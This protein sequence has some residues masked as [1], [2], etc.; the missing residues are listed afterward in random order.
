VRLLLGDCIEKMKELPENFVD[1]IICDPPYGLSFMGKKWDYD[2]P[3]LDIWQECLRVLKSGGTALIFAGSRTQHRMACNVEDSGFILKDCIMW[4]YG[5]GFPKATD[6]SKQLDKGHERKVIGKNPMVTGRTRPDGNATKNFGAGTNDDLTEPTT[7]E[8]KLWNGWKSHGLKPAYEPI[9]W[10]T[11]SLTVDKERSILKDVNNNLLFNVWLLLVNTQ[12][13]DTYKS[14]AMVSISLSIVL[15]WNAILGE[16]WK[17][18]SKFTTSTVSKTIIELKTLNFLLSKNTQEDTVGKSQTFQS[19]IQKFQVNGFNL[20]VQFAESCL[21]KEKKNINDILKAIV[22]ENATWNL[23]ENGINV[24][25]V[26]KDLLPIILNAN[27]VLSNVLGGLI[28]ENEEKE[29]REI[30]SF[31]EKSLKL[32]NQD[33]QNTVMSDVWLRDMPEIRPNYSPII[34]AMK[35]NEGSYAQNALEYGVSGL[36]IDGGRIKTAPDDVFGGGGLNSKGDGF[37]GKSKTPYE[38][39]MGFRNDNKQGRFP[40][41]I[42]LDEEA[43]KIIDKDVGDNVSRFFKQVDI[44]IEELSELPIS[45]IS[46]IIGR[47]R[48]TI[49]NKLK[50]LGL[51]KEPKK[52]VKNNDTERVCEICGE[53]KEI[54]EFAKWRSGKDYGYRHICKECQNCR[55]LPKTKEEKEKRKASSLAYAHNVRA[56]DRKEN[57]ITKE[58]VIELKSVGKCIYCGATN[59]EF[60]IDHIV[61]VAKGGKTEVIN[62]VLACARCNRSKNDRNLEEWYKEQPFY[63]EEKLRT[64]YC[65]KASKSERNMGCEELDKKQSTGG[66][67]GV[68]DYLDDV[69]SMSGKYG[70]EKAPA[71]NHHPTVKPIKLMEYLC[72]LTKTPTGG[73]VLDPFMGSGTTGIAC[74]N[75]DR[76]FIGIEK[77]P[78]YMEIAKKRIE[79]AVQKRKEKLF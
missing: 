78:E 34:V 58:D 17:N 13:L 66:G 55:W 10:A 49:R 73:I 53:L 30:V 16:L 1:T 59:T 35:P 15:L 28:I 63:N 64:F 48:K 32:C 21:G 52:Y 7:P 77:E 19:G 14:Q 20:L 76:E 24:L 36:N 37:I 71:K 61:P 8:A 67:G 23:K 45:E 41:N 68:G 40:A 4:I 39:G 6:I 57:K 51:Y 31:A 27:S 79:Y 60:Q 72:T 62:L 9:I 56:K 70:S 74:V 33:Q 65:A 42:I 25:S 5:S 12:N 54:E 47:D 11:K 46:R 43:G 22:Q 26:G 3:G 50:E 2:V 75:T 44:T 69:N 38:K 29:L 18:E